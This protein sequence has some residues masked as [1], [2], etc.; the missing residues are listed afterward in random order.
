MLTTLS[1]VTD[2]F[3]FSSRFYGSLNL[4]E[5]Q[6]LIL[7]YKSDVI[8]AFLFAAM[9]LRS[10]VGGKQRHAPCV[11]LSLHQIIFFVSD[12]FHGNHKTITRLR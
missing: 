12:E 11:A 3:M 8:C 9:C 6:V 5:D 2:F 7:S 10:V 1:L 4:M